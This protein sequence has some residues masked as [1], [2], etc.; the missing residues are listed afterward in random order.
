MNNKLA[1]MAGTMCVA[2]IMAA[3]GSLSQDGPTA[4]NQTENPQAAVP[5]TVPGVEPEA[6]AAVEVNI[7][8]TAE[9]SAEEAVAVESKPEENKAA[10]FKRPALP[11]TLEQLQP[12]NELAESDYSWSQLLPRDAIHPIYQPEFVPASEA[13]YADNELVIGV[14]ING[15]AKAYAIGP[16][17]SR[18]MVNDE[19]GG[20]PILVTW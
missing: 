17:N 4:A 18:E 20:V 8:P 11:L 19:L 7:A 16:L 6:G 13:P 10:I 12:K 3:C 14:E 9:T 5:A 15:E 1:G 2:A